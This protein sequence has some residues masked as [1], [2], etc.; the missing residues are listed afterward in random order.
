M[1]DRHSRC[2]NSLTFSMKVRQPTPSENRRAE[3]LGAMPASSGNIAPTSLDFSDR[4]SAITKLW[5]LCPV[6]NALIVLNCATFVLVTIGEQV[7]PESGRQWTNWGPFTLDGQWW[8][9]VTSTFIHLGPV[10]LIGNIFF[11]WVLGKRA[12]QLFGKW[13]F[14]GLYIACGVAGTLASLSFHPESITCGASGGTMGLA[15]AL[16]VAYSSKVHE[17]STRARWKLALLVLCTAYDAYPDSLAGHVD[18]PSHLGG[19]LA[20]LGLGSFLTSGFGETRLSKRWL[21]TGVTLVLLLSAGFIRH[22]N[23]YVISLRPV[24]LAMDEDRTDEVLQKAGAV[25]REHPN[26]VLAN[27]SVSEAFLKKGDYA[28]A[29]VAARHAL[30]TDPESGFADV[31]TDILATAELRTGRCAEA[32]SL[33]WR[34]SREAERYGATPP[35]LPECDWAAAGDHY[36]LDGETDQAIEAYNKALQVRPDDYRAQLGLAKAY[37]AKG[38]RKEAKEAAAKAAAMKPN[39]HR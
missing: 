16:I 10:H 37:E 23:G 3:D 5:R 25:L 24:I 35:Q 15:G 27:V 9:L 31:A 20:G 29:E 38:M 18:Y 11:L 19:L 6:T 39:T 4:A 33:T 28:K 30:A 12:E 21:F 1:P 13:T 8:R 32:R 34:R 2:S 17:L 14:L 26:S 7:W 36:L 22:S